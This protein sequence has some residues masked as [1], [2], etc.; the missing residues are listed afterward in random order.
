MLFELNSEIKLGNLKPFKGVHDVRIK[1]SILSYMDTAAI[2]IPA[3][4]RLKPK[5]D[6]PTRSVQTAKQ[7]QR[8]DKVLI[9]LGYNGDLRTEFE[10]FI[11]RVNLKTPCEI[12]CEGYSFQLRSKTVK[13]SYRS[14]NLKTVLQDIISGTDITLDADIPD[15]T[16]DKLNLA[17]LCGD[18]TEGI[19]VLDAL[20]KACGGALFIWFD[21]NVMYA[22]LGYTKI[23]NKLQPQKADV[24]YR[25]GWNVFRDEG[26]KERIKGD[27][28]FETYVGH[29]DKSGAYDKATA[30]SGGDAVKIVRLQQ[31]GSASDRKMI[32]EALENVKNYHGFEGRVTSFLQPYCQPAFK[33]KFIDPRYQE[34]DFSTIVDTM[35]VRYGR[36]G[37]R[38]IISFTHSL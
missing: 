3:T 27:V 16:L 34:R 24:V 35:E 9:K 20:K 1:K 38:R 11:S 29:R 37:A 6:Q 22:G 10:G 14:V 25:I 8:G 33:A 7:F 28:Q 26:M 12:E 17:V 30:G 4:A 19:P 5:G 21:K 32:A 13:K 15:I 36:N 18:P 2:K 23:M 31:V